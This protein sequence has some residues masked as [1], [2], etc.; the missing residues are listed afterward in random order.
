MS[1][2]YSIRSIWNKVFKRK[3]DNLGKT[4]INTKL[5][6]IRFKLTMSFLVMTIPI[7]LLGSISYYKSRNIVKNNT[8]SASIQTIGQTNKYLDMMFLRTISTAKQMYS[9]TQV[10]DLYSSNNPASMDPDVVTKRTQIVKMM[11]TYLS[12]DNNIGAILI[13]AQPG[14]SISTPSSYSGSESDLS[15]DNIKNGQWYKKFEESKKK[16]AW[17]GRHSELD[18]LGDPVL[19]YSDTLK[20]GSYISFVTNIDNINLDRTNQLMII[21]LKLEPIIETLKSINFG[22]NSQV[23]MIMPDGRDIGLKIDSKT[24]KSENTSDTINNLPFYLEA[25]RSKEKQGTQTVS[26]NGKNNLMIYSK[27]GQTGIMLVSLIPETN[28][29]MTANEIAVLTLILIFLGV[30]IS[31]GMALFVA[32]DIGRVINRLVTATNYAAQGDLTVSFKS[33]RKDEFA[34]L[35]NSI[36]DMI[37]NMKN[38]I[39]N[40]TSISKKVEESTE[41]M[42]TITLEASSAIQDI[43]EAVQGISLGAYAQARDVEEGVKKMDELAIKVAE[44][45]KTTKS[46]EKLSSDTMELAKLGLKTVNDLDKKSNETSDITKIILQDVSNLEKSSQSIG[47]IVKIIHGISDQTNLLALNAAIE[48]ARAGGAGVGF[49]VVANEIKKL[50]EE[51]MKET[52]EID[53][54][55]KEIQENTSM[56]VEKVRMTDNIVLSQNQAVASTLSLFENIANSMNTL[57]NFVSSIMSNI[58]DIEAAKSDTSNT[59]KN[60]YNISEQTAASVQEVTASTEEQLASIERISA[61]AEELNCN[62]KVLLEA[63]NKFKVK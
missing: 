50:A 6:S 15:L 44:A 24:N 47:N 35:T 41:T 1:K 37:S 29:L 54:I 3:K 62:V 5:K 60:I 38:L 55:I 43:A 8:I 21:D 32:T 36:A 9:N 56:T 31:I 22:A 45:D 57:V 26:F 33:K 25:L 61:F 30:I 7:I 23:H 17:I 39:G 4:S 49:A 20:S 27:V 14:A 34:V 28:L 53:K 51:T 12:T 10:M 58:S 59:I 18:A 46:I 63:I 16:S 42:A 52:R 48:A 19:K 40:T 11:N 2:R 13:A